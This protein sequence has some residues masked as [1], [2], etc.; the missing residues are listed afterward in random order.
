MNLKG[1]IFRFSY[2]ICLDINALR[3]QV[4]LKEPLRVCEVPAGGQVSRVG[5][6]MIS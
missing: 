4:W 6:Y 2:L 5:F 1:V 3:I